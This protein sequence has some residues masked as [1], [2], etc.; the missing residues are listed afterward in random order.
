MNSKKVGMVI[1]ISILSAMGVFGLSL[2]VAL[3]FPNM[4]TETASKLL[5]NTIQLDGLLFGFTAVMYGLF[6]GRKL[7]ARTKEV[8]VGILLVT[9]FLC[10]YFSLFLA[11]V[12]L[13]TQAVEGIILA[14]AIIS[15][16]GGLLSSAILTTELMD[17]EKPKDIVL[18]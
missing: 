11:F 6:Y 1:G 16:I 18:F 10:Y 8:K 12:F 9:S 14:P 4:S 7:I 17:T 15:I 2:A 3:A 13:A 5:E